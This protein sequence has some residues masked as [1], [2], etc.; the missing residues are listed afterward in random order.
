MKLWKFIVLACLLAWCGRDGARAQQKQPVSSLQEDCGVTFNFSTV[1]SGAQAAGT[2]TA[3][4]VG[5]TAV[6]DNRQSGCLDWLVTYEPSSTV[7]TLSL[8]FQ[9][10]LDVAGVPTTW[11]NYPGTLVSGINPNTAVTTG[12]A[13]TEATGTAYP[14]LRMNMTIKT[15]AGTVRGKLYGWKR[16]P[17]YVSVTS[18]GGCPGTVA[19]PCVVI[20]PTAAGVAPTTAPVLVAGRNTIPAGDGFVHEVQTDSNGRVIVAGISAP[21]AAI[22]GNPV[23]IGVRDNAGNAQ[24][25][26]SDTFGD[27]VPAGLATAQADGASNTPTVPSVGPAAAGVASTVRTYPYH[28]NGSTWDRQ[29]V[30]S[31]QARTLLTDGTRTQLVALAASQIIRVCHIHVTTTAV[32]DITISYGTGSACGTGTTT[33]DK[34]LSVQSFAM[35]F[36]PTAALRTIASN[37]LCITQSGTQNAEVTVIYA[38]F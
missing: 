37:A 18:G 3:G 7:A 20:G 9:T 12:G 14:F 11:S 34:Y 15:G 10:A 36:Q 17:T 16:R 8:A 27:L 38:I 26:A 1:S 21:N 30:C 35:D 33:I 2:T 24:Y 29:F 28:F 13:V 31:N 25:A 23:P 5:T 22:G 32:E 19:T 4:S 6:I